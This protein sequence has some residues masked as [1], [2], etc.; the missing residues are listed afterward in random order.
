MGSGGKEYG[1]LVESEKIK[2]VPWMK[3]ERGFHL[4]RGQDT[5]YLDLPGAWEAKE[6]L[7]SRQTKKKRK[8]LEKRTL[9]F[10]AEMFERKDKVS[11]PFDP[12]GYSASKPKRE[13]QDKRN[14]KPQQQA[15]R[16]HCH[17]R[18]RRKSSNT[19]GR[20]SLFS[21]FRTS[22]VVVVLHRERLGWQRTGPWRESK[23]EKKEGRTR[24]WKREELFSLVVTRHHT[25][26]FVSHRMTFRSQESSTPMFCDTYSLAFTFSLD[27]YE[28]KQLFIC[29]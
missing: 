23:R 7:R 19:D 20:K 18:G 16:N 24:G 22:S 25:S 13:T 4:N 10:E 2:K 9:K 21:F 5:A 28:G 29:S 8:R 6:F 14:N 12:L 26:L 17:R 15:F 3:N 1:R 27:K 11:F